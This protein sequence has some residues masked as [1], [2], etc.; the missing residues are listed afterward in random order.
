GVPL[1]SASPGGGPTPATSLP[2]QRDPAAAGVFGQRR[3]IACR[4]QPPTRHPDH[5]RPQVPAGPP[6]LPHGQDTALSPPQYSRRH[7]PRRGRRGAQSG[8]QQ[9]EPPGEQAIYGGRCSVRDG[10]LSGNHGEAATP[11]TCAPPIRLSRIRPGEV[12][13]AAVPTSVPSLPSSSPSFLGGVQLCLLP[14]CG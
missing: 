12:E 5:L 8:R 13:V 9:L 10:Y 3:I 11:Q 1:P 14:L 6:Q 2:G 4:A 7:Q